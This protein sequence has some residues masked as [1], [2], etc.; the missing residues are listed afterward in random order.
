MHPSQTYPSDLTDDEW[1]IIKPLIAEAKKGGRP[2]EHSRRM[3]LNAIFFVNRSGCQWSMLPRDFPPKSTVSDSFAAWRKS[4]LWEG[5]NHR[6]RQKVRVAEARKPSPS[7][8]ILGSQSVKGAGETECPER[9]SARLKVETQSPPT[10][11]I[12][13]LTTLPQDPSPRGGSR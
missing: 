2:I 1:N 13:R 11:P 5:L 6:L 8:A 10:S 7:A 4:G 3:I 9:Q 12:A